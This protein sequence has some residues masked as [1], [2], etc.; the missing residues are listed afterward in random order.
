MPPKANSFNFELTCL[1]C[2]EKFRN[3]TDIKNNGCRKLS[4]KC[5]CCLNTF[6]VRNKLA[7]HLNQKGIYLREPMIPP[8]ATDLVE[9]NTD[10]L[11]DIEQILQSVN[12]PTVHTMVE[13]SQQQI[14]LAVPQSNLD[15]SDESNTEVAE[16]LSIPLIKNV[17]EDQISETP[18][19][20]E[21]NTEPI[22]P[23]PITSRGKDI[24]NLREH[25]SSPEPISWTCES[26]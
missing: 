18:T 17:V 2:L 13:I 11:D 10:T 5:G 20:T 23:L 9:Q 1:V 22:E 6:T 25:Y 19:N 26:S 3:Q 24:Q 14:P 15:S 7:E 21:Q 12:I 16:I 4:I 8:T